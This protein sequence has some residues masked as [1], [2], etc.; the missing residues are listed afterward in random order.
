MIH[1]LKQEV[2]FF[3]DVINGRKLFEVR[4]NDRNYKVMDLI[5]LNEW[6]PDK[7]LYTGR[8]CLVYIDYILDDEVYVKEGHIVKEGYIVMTIKPCIVELKTSPNYAVRMECDYKVPLCP[9][10][11]LEV[12]S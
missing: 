11:K 9:I 2:Q 7:N 8:S 1:A 12:S 3:E 10:H 6:D 5:A 4:K